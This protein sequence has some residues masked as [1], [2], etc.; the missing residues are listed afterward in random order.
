[1]ASLISD[2]QYVTDILKEGV[3]PVRRP[4]SNQVA[5][6]AGTIKQTLRPDNLEGW[7]SNVAEQCYSQLI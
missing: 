2:I 6:F 7:C 4:V 3:L 5:L 1:M